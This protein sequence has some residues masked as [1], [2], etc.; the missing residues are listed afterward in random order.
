MNI[1]SVELEWAEETTTTY[2]INNSQRQQQQQQ[3]QRLRQQQR[4]RHPKL[5]WKHLQTLSLKDDF[6]PLARSVITGNR[7]EVVPDFGKARLTE[8]GKFVSVSHL[9]RIGGSKYM[10]HSST[11]TTPVADL[12]CCFLLGGLVDRWA[13]ARSLLDVMVGMA[14]DQTSNLHCSKPPF[15]ILPLVNYLRRHYRSLDER[16][17]KKTALGSA[18]TSC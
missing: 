6:T 15:Q 8:Q 17:K 16:I 9:F 12:R 18:A 13:D 3:Q 4:Q 1:L 5:T 14:T 11:T 7:S 10:S 2:A